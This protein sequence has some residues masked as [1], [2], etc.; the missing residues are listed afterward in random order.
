[1]P[2]RWRPPVLWALLI[3]ALVLWPNPPEV[4]L[5]WTVIWLDFMKLDK[6]VHTALFAVLTVLLMRASLVASRPRPAALAAFG[7][8]AAFGAFTELQQHFIPT[9]A[10]EFGDFLADASGAAVGLLVFA[11]WALR[12]REFSR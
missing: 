8:S 9:R 1:M 6:L 2:A 11:A 12:R 4:S 10:M 7:L 3:E 5:G